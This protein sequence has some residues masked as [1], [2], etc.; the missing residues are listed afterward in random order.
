M[1]YRILKF[2]VNKAVQI[3]LELLVLKQLLG[4]ILLG[5]EVD[6]FDDPNSCQGSSRFS[7]GLQ[8]L[9]Y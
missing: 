6:D 8:H 3:G 4:R 9:H 7:E 2:L 1:N 5:A